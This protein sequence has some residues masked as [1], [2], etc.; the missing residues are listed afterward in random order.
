MRKWGP[1]Q[2][3]PW[4]GLTWGDVHGVAVLRQLGPH[5]FAEH[6]I[7]A[8]EGSPRRVPAAATQVEGD[9]ELVRGG[10]QELD[11]MLPLIQREIGPW[12]ALGGLALD[13]DGVLLAAGM[14]GHQQNGRRWDRQGACEMR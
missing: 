7:L 3:G 4:E 1:G 10:L 5:V 11:H 14:W 9:L 12:V 2:R 6:A 13:V 8:V